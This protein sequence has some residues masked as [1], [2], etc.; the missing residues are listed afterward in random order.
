MQVLQVM[1]RFRAVLARQTSA[2][3]GQ[4]MG[5]GEANGVA[6]R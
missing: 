2:Q 6:E 5:L 4:R 3:A 1:R